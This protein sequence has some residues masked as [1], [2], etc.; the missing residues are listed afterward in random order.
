M[1]D[2]HAAADSG[3]C[4]FDTTVNQLEM[5]EAAEGRGGGTDR[6]ARWRKGGLAGK[7]RQQAV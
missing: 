6:Q 5:R 2:M 1:K 7:R 4:D 3:C